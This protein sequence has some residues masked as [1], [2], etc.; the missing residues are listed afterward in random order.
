MK[1]K[2]TKIILLIIIILS[3]LLRLYKIESK[4]NFDWDQENISNLPHTNIMSQLEREFGT[5]RRAEGTYNNLY[6]FNE[7]FKKAIQQQIREYWLCAWYYFLNRYK[8]EFQNDD[9]KRKELIKIGD[10]TMEALDLEIYKPIK[11][12]IF[13]IIVQYDK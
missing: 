7:G 9:A 4:V 8:D 2:S 1:L 5:D 11:N 13:D 6:S 10:S 12:Q 3:T